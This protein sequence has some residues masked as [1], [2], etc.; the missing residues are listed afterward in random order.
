M[1]TITHGIAGAVIAKAGFSKRLGKTGTVAGVISAI[2][3][4]ADIIFRFFGD[5]AFLKYH[6]GLGNSLFFMIPLAL[7]IALIFNRFSKKKA[8]GL[9]FLLAIL[10]IMSHNFLDLQTSF[11]TMLLYPFSD[12]RFSLDLVFIIDL[13]Y[14]GLFIAG[15]IIAYLWK[16][17]GEAIS[18][19]TLLTIILYTGL[20][21][22][23]HSKA[24][25][26]A[27][28]FAS[29]QKL[30]AINIS[31][32]PQP[33]SPFLWANYIDTEKEIYQGF[34]DLKNKNPETIKPDTYIGRFKSKFR[35]PKNVEYKFWVKF[36]DSPF[37]DMALKLEGL[38][39]FLWFARFPV[40]IE[41]KDDGDLH[42]LR[43]FDLQFSAMEGRYP[44]L[45]EVVFNRQGNVIS[46]KFI[47]GSFLR[48]K[49]KS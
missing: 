4:D 33:L 21:A 18:I 5:E 49:G 40:L 22:Y 2:L 36:P 25:S 39:F 24:I 41:E 47:N 15:L 45:Y 19:L 26:L 48:F 20:C 32:L 44:F 17:R 42:I 1:D 37:A 34:V 43:F 27:K 13:Y 31:S 35:S 23:N 29:N 46:Q 10:G 3:P 28:D 12:R 6:R 7:F 16:K 8:F 9:F 14:T 11:G 30:N 38:K